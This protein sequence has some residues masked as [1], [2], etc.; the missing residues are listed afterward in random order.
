VAVRDFGAGIDP[1]NM[2]RMFD[3]FFTTKPMGI[4]MGLPLSRSIV[5][6][7]GGKIWAQVN[8]GPGLTV[9]FILPAESGGQLSVAAGKD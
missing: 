8:E 7:H 1:E 6:A 5:E 3:A 9:Q 2:N 4:G